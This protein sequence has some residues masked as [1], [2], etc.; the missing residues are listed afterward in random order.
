MGTRVVVLVLSLMLLLSLTYSLSPA[1]PYATEETSVPLMVPVPRPSSMQPAPTSQ[2]VHAYPPRWSAA[3]PMQPA[4]NQL[5]P[6][7]RASV[8]SSTIGA[9]NPLTVI[10]SVF[11]IPGKLVRALS[12]DQGG[13]ASINP[14]PGCLPMSPPGYR[15]PPAPYAASHRSAGVRYVLPNQPRGMR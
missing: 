7:A 15:V 9:L 2:S 12:G 5:P 10:A 6:F 3:P 1:A 13:P 8:A 4:Y 11:T 14:P